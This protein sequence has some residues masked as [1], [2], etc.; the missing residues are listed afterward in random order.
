MDDIYKNIEEYSPNKIRKIFIVF[1]D[2]IAD[3]LS[4]K[5]LNPIKT[6][7]FIRDL[8]KIYLV[9]ITQFYFAVPKNISLNSRNRIIQKQL[10]LNM[11]KKYLKKDIYLHKKTENY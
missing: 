1:N 6:E 3:T 10:Q 7:L 11:I 2:M 8:L 5:K 9:F 4:N